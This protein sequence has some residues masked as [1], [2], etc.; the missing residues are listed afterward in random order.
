MP[1][2]KTI[3]VRRKGAG[4]DVF[5]INAADFDVKLWE[6]AVEPQAPPSVA[7]PV[8][9]PAK[10]P[11]GAKPEVEADPAAPAKGKKGAKRS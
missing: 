10:E 3:R 6:M 2:P 8:L 4:G 5:T 11:E 9:P 1:N 7:A